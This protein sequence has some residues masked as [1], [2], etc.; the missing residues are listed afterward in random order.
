M[1]DHDAPL[2]TNALSKTAL[3]SS[4]QHHLRIRLLVPHFLAS[5]DGVKAAGRTSV[6]LV[7]GEHGLAFKVLRCLS[8]HKDVRIHILSS[9]Q[10]SP[11]RYSRHVATFLPYSI[12][13]D[14]SLESE[15]RKAAQS[16]GSEV[17]LACSAPGTEFLIRRGSTIPNIRLMQLP[18]LRAFRAA[19]DKWA[20]HLTAHSCGTDSPRTCLA[21]GSGLPEDMVFPVLLKPRVGE[22]GRGILRVNNAAE[23]T[24]GLQLSTVTPGRY[25]VQEFVHGKNVGCSVICQEGRILACTVQQ[26]IR[27]QDRGF[28]SARDIRFRMHEGAVALANKIVKYLNWTG[29]AHFDMRIR[30]SDGRVLVLEMNPRFWASIYGSLRA[31]VDFVSLNCALAQAGSTSPSTF[32][33]LDYYQGFAAFGPW[34]RGCPTD[35]GCRVLDPLPDLMQKLS[36]L[37]QRF[38]GTRS[39]NLPAD[40]LDPVATVL[41]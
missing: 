33:E 30:D 4:I 9:D 10:K 17:L 5:G 40:T 14:D 8:T 12:R 18:G 20:F 36:T 31:G 1:S 27:P 24:A 23:L 15:V 11:I 39:D 34:L 25:I 19:N 7:D 6:L 16:T 32:S 26:P 29:V 35:F 13:S 37:R 41:P 21:G 28:A 2:L 3:N 22:S 38:T